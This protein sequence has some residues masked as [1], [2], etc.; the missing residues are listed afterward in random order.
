MNGV[1]DASSILSA[2]TGKSDVLSPELCRNSC[3]DAVQKPH[4]ASLFQTLLAEPGIST[5]HVSHRGREW[6]SSIL[7]Q[8]ISSN[9]RSLLPHPLVPHTS[10]CST[11]LQAAQDTP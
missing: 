6:A 4:P 1:S 10:L 3:R 9:F 11:K 5:T 8:P 2:T 7:A